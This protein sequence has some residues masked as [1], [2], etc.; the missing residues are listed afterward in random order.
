MSIGIYKITSPSGKVYIGQSIKIE[1]RWN[2]Y[3]NFNNCDDQLKLYR[4]LKKHGW[5][6]HK[7]DII[8]ECPLEQ[9]NERETHWK[10]YYL[11]QVQGKWS[12][13][14]FCDLYDE[15]GG[16]RSEETKSKISKNHPR[17][18]IILQKDKDGSFIKEYH[19]AGFA[20]RELGVSGIS[21]ANCAGGKQPTAYGYIWEYKVNPIP[22]PL[23]TKPVIQYDLNMN[24]INEFPSSRKAEMYFSKSKSDNVGACCRGKQMTAY[25]YIWKFKE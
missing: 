25:G 16:P 14:L 22:Q 7:K 15:G 21:I 17:G 8:E 3:K 18:K 4:S 24:Q 1:K 12:E 10:I 20:G 2:D 13:V 9:L 5:D 19:S 11:S 23:R 6:N